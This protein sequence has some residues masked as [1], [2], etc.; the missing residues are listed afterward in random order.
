M[1]IYI[2]ESGSKGNATLL[3]HDGHVL[4]IDMG[5]SLT[6]LKEALVSIN[7]KLIDVQAL[8][9]THSHSDHTK[10]IKYLNPLPI[11]CTKDTYDTLETIEIKPY[12]KFNLFGIDI[13]P[14]STSHD[15]PNPV[16][17]VFKTKTEKLVYMTDTGMIPER[18][19]SKMKNANYYV[20]EAN[21][22]KKMLHQTNRPASLKL[23]ILSDEGHLSNEDSAIYMSDLVGEKTTDIVLAHLSEEAN[24]PEVALSA[25]E[26]IFKK[27]HIDLN[28]INVR[29]ASQHEVVAILNKIN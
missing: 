16:G 27:H 11:Y 19:L 24:R 12:V 26:R 1:N 7:K 21:H 22:N 23:R 2:I 25:Y 4:L 8:F 17:Y 9:L 5:V 10:G 28:K 15:A 18:S 6:A 13:T 29:C 20:I 14:I 3:E